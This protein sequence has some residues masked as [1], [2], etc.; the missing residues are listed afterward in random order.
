MCQAID[1]R[2]YNPGVISLLRRLEVNP[3]THQNEE[4]LSHRSY[5]ES[6]PTIGC[7]KDSK[8]IFDRTIDEKKIDFSLFVQKL[9]FKNC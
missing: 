1:E 5:Q 4:A 2:I 3:F 9:D 6:I 7:P 8:E